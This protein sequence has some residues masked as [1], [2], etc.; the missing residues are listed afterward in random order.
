V[1]STLMGKD[2]EMSMSPKGP[3]GRSS[4]RGHHPLRVASWV[5]GILALAGAVVVA[6]L[7]LPKPAAGGTCGP[8]RGSEPAIVA[9][10]DPASI[11]AGPRP[12]SPAIAVFEWQAFVGECQASTNAR[13]VDALALVLLSAFFL[14][15]ASPLVGRAWRR[16]E[17]MAAQ[18]APPGWYPD[19]SE[20][21]PWRW[22]DGQRWSH[23]TRADEPPAGGT[24]APPTIA[25][26]PPPP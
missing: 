9:F 4:R 18:A 21:A 12:S 1:T 7:P 22:W 16:H 5:V 6:V 26:P 19:P 15:I 8:G 25:E 11:G 20:S 10:F 23:Q 14:L 3:S 17:V 24:I 13:I 2:E